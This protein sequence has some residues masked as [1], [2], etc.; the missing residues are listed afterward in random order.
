[1]LKYLAYFELAA[2]VVAVVFTGLAYSGV[3]PF[4]SAVEVVREGVAR[5]LRWTGADREPLY[6]LYIDG[7][8]T[9]DGENTY[10]CSGYSVF[11]IRVN[12]TAVRIAIWA[13]GNVT[14]AY[15]CDFAACNVLVDTDRQ[16]VVEVY[17]V[18][19]YGAGAE[20]EAVNVTAVL[21][22][23]QIAFSGDSYTVHYTVSPK[24]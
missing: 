11:T 20:W 4:R 24:V 16:V 5:L 17:P 7:S 10:R 19:R 1:M 21:G 8:C 22:K 23:F 2:I 6:N 9:A 14:S 18:F 12:N 15:L 13:D 3:E